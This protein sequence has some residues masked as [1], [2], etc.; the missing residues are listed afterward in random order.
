MKKLEEHI[1]NIV[2][3]N[4]AT[5][6]DI[7]R[8]TEN[9]NQYYIVYIRSENGVNLDL[10][11]KIS[12]IISPLL[13]VEDS[14]DKKYF[15]EVS[16]PGLERTLHS[17]K[18]FIMSVKELVKVKLLDGTKLKGMLNIADNNGITVDETVVLYSD[19]KSAKTY[20]QWNNQDSKKA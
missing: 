10:C 19:I 6:Y 12:R 15:L 1:K 20:M 3:D 13:D 14:F 18:N 17:K 5:I 7:V 2:E 16:S 11:G 9:N 8:R 4:G